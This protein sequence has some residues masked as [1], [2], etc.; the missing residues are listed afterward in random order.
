MPGADSQR[1]LVFVMLN[2]EALIGMRQISAEG[3]TNRPH[4]SLCVHV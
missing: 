3:L 4:E 1:S 2:A